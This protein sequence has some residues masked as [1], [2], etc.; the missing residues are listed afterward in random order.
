[1]AAHTRTHIHIYK[2]G[3]LILLADSEPI[4]IALY[5][6][7]SRQVLSY[8]QRRES[9]CILTTLS[10]NKLSGELVVCYSFTGK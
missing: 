5:H 1:M 4:L 3:C 6:V 10:F 9:D 2:T 8:Y 7:P